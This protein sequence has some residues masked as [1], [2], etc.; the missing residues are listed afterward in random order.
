MKILVVSTSLAE[1]SRSRAILNYAAR[2]LEKNSFEINFVDLHAHSVQVY[3]RSASDPFILNLTE[4]FNSCSGLVLGGP[5]H[6]WSA[7]ASLMNLL[8]YVLDPENAPAFRPTILIAGAGSGASLL[9]LENVQRS[10]L[11]EIKAVL[12]GPPVIGVK[13]DVDRETGELSPSLKQRLDNSL[14]AFAVY[15]RTYIVNFTK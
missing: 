10:L 5:V 14:T 11:H 4:V 8:A 6:N 9:A 3:P 1:K 12:I 2:E 13:D 15:A 7:G